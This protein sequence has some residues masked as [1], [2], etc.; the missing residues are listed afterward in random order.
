VTV[1]VKLGSSLVT[2]GGGR[3]RRGLLAARAA[4]LA[5]IV[6]AGESACVV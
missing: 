3:V 1:V 4:D 2:D 6:R 5:A